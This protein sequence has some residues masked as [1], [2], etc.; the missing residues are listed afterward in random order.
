MV[1]TGIIL[2]G[3]GPDQV[4][5]LTLRVGT[6]A[7]PSS[8]GQGQ[9]LGGGRPRRLP[10]GRWSRSA[11]G[12]G[13][14]RRSTSALSQPGR[15]SHPWLRPWRT[16]AWMARWKAPFLKGSRSSLSFRVPSG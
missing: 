11:S 9:V 16:W 10:S 15:A 1:A 6:A 13:L 2:A 12:L 5:A 3:A 4:P 7:L 8:A 14:A